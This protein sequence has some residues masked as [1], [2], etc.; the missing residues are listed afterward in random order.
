MKLLFL[1]KRRPQGKDLLERPYGR[2]YYLPKILAEKGHEFHILLLSYKNEPRIAENKDRI[3][4]TSISLIK[5]GPFAYIHEA[6]KIIQEICPDW[7]I[8]FS[9]Y[10][11]RYPNA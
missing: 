10:L 6:K 11:L 5:H 4:W 7:I 9:G 3:N 8:G 2:F 1:C